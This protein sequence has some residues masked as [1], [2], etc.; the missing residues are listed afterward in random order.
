MLPTAVL[1]PPHQAERPADGRS[2]R[3][4]RS[5]VVAMYPGNGR[6]DDQLLGCAQ[7]DICTDTATRDGISHVAVLRATFAEKQVGAQT[8]YPSMN[9]ASWIHLR[10][11]LPP[12]RKSWVWDLGGRSLRHIGAQVR[13]YRRENSNRVRTHRTIRHETVEAMVVLQ[14]GC[15]WPV[16]RWKKE[17]RE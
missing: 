17:Q 3:E 12:T 7:M 9:R 4:R 16:L 15:R 6:L 14:K 11:C 1:I 8:D 10:Y 2:R 13:F 5:H